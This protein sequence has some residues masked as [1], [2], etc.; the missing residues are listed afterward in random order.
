MTDARRDPTWAVSLL[1]TASCGTER[2]L[3]EA[4]IYLEPSGEMAVDPFISQMWPFI[5][6]RMVEHGESPE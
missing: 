5:P 3:R 2:V 6:D 4:A 1:I